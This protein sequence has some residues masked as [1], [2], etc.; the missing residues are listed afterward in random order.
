MLIAYFLY[1]TLVTPSVPIWKR[2][3]VLRLLIPYT[4]GLLLQD[5]FTLPP[6]ASVAGIL[7]AMVALTATVADRSRLRAARLRGALVSALALGFGAL[8][9][10]VHD[11][12]NDA[13]WFGRDY[14]PGETLL[15]SLDEPPIEKPATYK[16]I[17]RVTGI[18]RAGILRRTTGKVIL[19]FR[20]SARSS[21]LHYG[22]QVAT[23]Q[24]LRPVANSGN[25]GGF[26]YRRYLQF[27]GITHQAFLADAG[28]A[29]APG[30]GARPVAR[31]VFQTR[32]AI[33]RLL[34]R[35]ISNPRESGLAEALLIGYK[36]D[37]DKSL[38]RSYTNTGVVH[39]IAISGLHL[40]LVYGLLMALTR[41][42]R[43]RRWRWWRLAL[44]VG[45]LWTFTL[46]AGAQPSVLRAA[47]MFTAL[48]FANVLDRHHAVGNA[49]ALSAFLLLAWNPFWLW[50]AGFQLSYAAVLGILLF[51]KPLHR[52]LFLDNRLLD[53]VAQLI[54]ASMAAQ[55]LTLPI[56][57]YQ[58]H[59]F[60]LLFLLA[61]IVAVPL[62]G[63]IVYGEILI[64][65][66]APLPWLARA[67]G[68]VVEAMLRLMNGFVGRLDRVSFALWDGLSVNVAQVVL[69]YG[70]IAVACLWLQRPR[71][72]L[73]YGAI[74][75]AAGFLAIRSAAFI[76]ADRQQAI[77]VYNLPKHRAID[78]VQ[79]R[80]ALFAG[81]AA[82]LSDE[83]INANSL[84]PARTANRTSVAGTVTGSS[85][86]FGRLTVLLVDASTRLRAGTDRP[87][88]DLLIVSRNP[89]ISLRDAATCLRVTQVVLDGSMPPS[90]ARRWQRD[91]ATLGIACY[92]VVENGAFTAVL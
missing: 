10:T 57:L 25:P 92:N 40:A 23:R 65:L 60:P 42:A 54:A 43:G 86:R 24:T 11:T 89:R 27:Q 61:N 49:L 81:D 32:A 28:F 12:R 17:A 90:T 34:R 79:G 18:Y 45:S 59:Q 69:M 37:L 85:F 31:L 36:D 56:S 4:G 21:A 22:S 30:S 6:A 19:Y 46:L 26:D 38:V 76:K 71:R 41:P 47:V 55:V 84:R 50:D 88:A 75:C 72:W 16:A 3:P 52:L 74:G 78:L 48:A 64:C 53:G 80:R 83:A 39:I 14:Q 7:I 67:A 13:S 5:I 82:V 91:A 2:V 1:L 77:I 51:Y 29:N 33:A 44:V 63:L 35:S 66:L 15:L 73:A 68:S 20:K 58:F 9:Y 87:V 70:L 8:S 62:S